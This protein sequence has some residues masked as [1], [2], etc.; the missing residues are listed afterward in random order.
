MS[1][2]KKNYPP[3]INYNKKLFLRLNKQGGD[4]IEK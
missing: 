1:P 2:V 4:I 3:K